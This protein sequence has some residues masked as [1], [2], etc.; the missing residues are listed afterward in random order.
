MVP[1]DT[2]KIAVTGFAGTGK[3]TLCKRLAED[4]DLR[5][6]GE[7]MVDITRANA[8]YA[9]LSADAAAPRETVV[10]A[11]TDVAKAFAGW[12]A[13]RADDY[14][15][16]DRL[17]ADRWEADLLAM[18]LMSFACQQNRVDEVTVRLLEDMREKA[19]LFDFIVMLPVTQPFVKHGSVNDDGLRRNIDFT[20]HLLDFSVVYGLIHGFASQRVIHVPGELKTAEQRADFVLAKV[21]ESHSRFSLSL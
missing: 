17:V 13:K 9:R 16:F 3:T 1:H 6:L 12:T 4:L 7:G 18:W 5:V 21:R 15:C 11:K 8:A 10:A 19:K 20:T 2:L 14:A